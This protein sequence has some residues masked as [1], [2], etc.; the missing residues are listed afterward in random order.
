MFVLKRISIKKFFVYVSAQ[1]IG[2]FLGSLS[3]YMIYFEMINSF[4]PEYTM[5]TASI[6]STYPDPRLS[7]FGG[8]LDQIFSTSILL[9]FILSITDERNEKFSPGI[10]FLKIQFFLLRLN[11]NFKSVNKELLRRSLGWQSLL[12]VLRLGSTV[13]MQLIQRVISVPE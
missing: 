3:V 7:I 1:L 2:A 9:I 4:D 13:D 6:F 5:K 8:I 11:L 12:L 10:H